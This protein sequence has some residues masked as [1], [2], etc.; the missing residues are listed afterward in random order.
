[1][2]GRTSS[3]SSYLSVCLS[4]CLFV[5]LSV[6]VSV[7][8]SVCLL[9]C[10]SVGLL[11][12]LAICLSVYPRACGGTEGVDSASGFV[13]FFGSTNTTQKHRRLVPSLY[14]GKVAI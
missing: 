14:T 11:G 9:V 8:V 13:S 5:D 10:L 1:M 3:P 4:V 2:T 12:L 6:C 7:C